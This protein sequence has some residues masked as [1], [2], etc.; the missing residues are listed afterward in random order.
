MTLKSFEREK[1]TE[2]RINSVVG[3]GAGDVRLGQSVALICRS[4][5]RLV[6]QLVVDSIEDIRIDMYDNKQ[7][8]V[9]CHLALIII[10]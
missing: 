6:G 1:E 8:N 10:I 3:V 4:V 7:Q 5:G 9:F 2:N